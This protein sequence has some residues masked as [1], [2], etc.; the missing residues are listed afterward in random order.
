MTKPSVEVGAIEQLMQEWHAGWQNSDIEALLALFTD[1]AVLMPQ[2]QPVVK[3]KAAIR[4]LYETFFN[5]YTVKGECQ[6]QEVEVSGDLGYFWVNYTLTATS[7]MQ[8]ESIKDDSK[9]VFI[10]RRQPDKAWKIAR[11]MDNSNREKI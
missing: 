10:V 8:G 6:L 4:S 1:D 9:S 7:K 2:G 5:S 11:L 3:G